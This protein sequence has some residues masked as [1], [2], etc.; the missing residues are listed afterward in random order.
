[1]P[2][3]TA[4]GPD[5]AQRLEQAHHARLYRRYPVTL[6]EGRGARVTD[7]AGREYIDALA[8]IAVNSVGHCHP[9][10]VAAI[11]D[12]AGRLIHAS[13]LYYFEPQGRLAARLTAAA[14]LERVF[15]TNSGTEAVEG[16]LKLA[17]RHAAR[18][19]RRGGVI[20]MQGCF[21]GRSTGALSMHSAK[22][23]AAFEPLLEGFRQIPFNDAAALADALDGTTVAVILEPVQG[24][25]GMRPADPAYLREVRR[26]CDENGAVMILDEIQ[27]GAGRTGT[28]FAFQQADVRPDIV[29]AAKALGGGV[30]IGAVLARE[31]IVA[32]FDYGDHGTTYGGNPLACAAADAAV[33]VIQEEKLADRARELGAHLTRR[34]RE[35]QESRPSIREVR[36]LGLMVGVELAFPGKPIV[37]A[38]LERGVLSNCTAETV[39]RF[40]PPLVISREDLDT[41]VDVFLACLDEEAARQDGKETS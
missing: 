40:V 6:V 2:T 9:E 7:S 36:G 11:R 18:H 3:P 17:R 27:C 14:G 22:Q 19:G 32:A 13:N 8:G 1:M 23:R 39:M 41:V 20:S 4:D 15:F 5:E 38:M 37:G 28:F 10:V 35:A 34:L 26:L 29:T 12:Q 16:A 33:R 24:E 25:G 21:H 30:P 31:E